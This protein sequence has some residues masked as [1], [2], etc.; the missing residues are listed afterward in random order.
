MAT[1]TANNEHGACR[2]RS[3]IN[4]RHTG[5]REQ[6]H[7][8]R[9]AGNLT[10]GKLRDSI[11]RGQ[12]LS[13]SWAAAARAFQRPSN[14][15]H[16][17]LR[18]TSRHRPTTP[19][20]TSSPPTLIAPP[21]RRRR[22][23]TTTGTAAM[24]P[25]T[26]TNTTATSTSTSTTP[27]MALT[28]LPYTV[29]A[30]IVSYLTAR[31]AVAARRTAAFHYWD[32]AWAC[33]PDAGLLVHPVEGRRYV[34]RDVDVDAGSGSGSDRRAWAVPFDTT[35]RL[36]RRVRLS[37]GILIF[38]WCEKQAV[39]QDEGEDGAHRHFATAYDVKRV[40]RGGGHDDDDGE[41]FYTL[42]RYGKNN[43][44]NDTGTPQDEC[45]VTFRAEWKIHC[46]G[47]L[48]RHQD[49]F[50]STHNSTHYAVYIWQPSRS[51]WGEDEPRERLIVWELGAPRGGG[52][53][54]GGGSSSPRIMM[55]LTSPQLD[56][57]GVRQRGTPTLRSLGLDDRTW[58]PSAGAARGHVFVVEE[59]HR[60]S[61]GPHS[62]PT[63]PR[64]HHVKTT[65][66]PLAGAGP[67]WVDECGKVRS[68]ASPMQFCWRGT[69]GRALGDQNQDQHQ[70]PAPAPAPP[71]SQPPPTAGEEREAGT[72]DRETWAGRC[73]CWRHD[74]FPY[75]TVCEVSDARAGVRFSARHC[76]MLETL[77]VH[78]KPRLRV[79]GVAQPIIHTAQPASSST[80]M[81]YTER[82]RS[83][84]SS[85]SSSSKCVMAIKSCGGAD[86]PKGQRRRHAYEAVDGGRRNGSSSSSSSS[87][88]TSSGEKKSKGFAV[89]NREIQF[90]DDAWTMLLN[91]GY[92]CGDERWL[93][94]EDTD[95]SI[96]I[97]HF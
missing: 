75:L 51:P 49:R 26:L 94:G 32:P 65:G 19:P 78:I 87:N 24:K 91:A 14:L 67:R 3:G 89:A 76:F 13:R 62:S 34:L 47:I 28:D 29:F 18:V 66:I 52:G 71:P 2:P 16:G 59:E 42:R 79:H 37:H 63:P 11:L 96:T 30:E 4:D 41:D 43:L 55:Q 77:S 85:S 88:M 57:W 69:P 27:A 15:P 31:E 60:W 90:G 45:T 95:G 40:R 38:E 82:R 56:H 23:G 80:K 12:A 6:E 73:P 53:G 25:T 64:L 35:G 61:A 72:D 1:T 70:V 86:H 33:D 39:R 17:P 46:L 22:S 84:S 74:D 93:I 54:G 83:R 97:M 7:G 92:I 20:P 36:V 44:E 58:D 50:F 5:R 48:L 8:L 68:G 10:L 81:P 21:H 9:R